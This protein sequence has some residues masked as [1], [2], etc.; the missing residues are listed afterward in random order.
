MLSLIHIW[1]GRS[2]R[3][4]KIDEGRR[5]FACG[6]LDRCLAL[7]PASKAAGHTRP[8]LRHDDAAALP[9]NGKNTCEKADILLTNAPFFAK[10]EW[11]RGEMAELV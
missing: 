1:Q 6:R 9:R 5:H 2:T 11:R 7:Y 8:L 4:A 10:I 3:G